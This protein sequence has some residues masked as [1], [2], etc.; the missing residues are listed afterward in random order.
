MGP[1]I[2]AASLAKISGSETVGLT[3]A[4]IYELDRDVGNISGI[5]GTK[6]KL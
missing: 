3:R 5:A 1:W 4:R 6:A 2:R